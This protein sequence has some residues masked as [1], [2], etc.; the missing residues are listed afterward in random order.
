MV[1]VLAAILIAPLEMK[2]PEGSL[3]PDAV[4]VNGIVHVAYQQNQN[5]WY[6]RYG[7]QDRVRINSTGGTVQAGGERGPKIAVSGDNVFAVWQGDYRLGPKVWFSRSAD[8]G[9]TFETQRNLVDGKTP[10][11]DEITVAAAGDLVAVFWLDGRTPEDAESPVTSGIWYSLS[12]D[13]GKT[14]GANQQIYT[15]EKVRVCSCCSLSVHMSSNESADIAYRSGIKN[16][17]E[18]YLLTGNIGTNS[19]RSRKV[20]T[21]YW[22]LGGCPMD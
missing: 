11:L 3:C 13:R 18:T 1:A 19:F 12:R 14:F 21:G 16:V 6:T 22:V 5:G 15:P 9:K 10:G 2:L 4:N 20:S 8:G 17:R 7:S